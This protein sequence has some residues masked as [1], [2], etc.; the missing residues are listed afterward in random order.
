MPLMSI[1]GCTEFEK[2]IV[3]LL[4]ED[5]M[6]DHLLVVN[7]SKSLGLIS[8]LKKMGLVPDVLSPER[9][10]SGLKKS[11]GFN[12]LVTLQ[13]VNVYQSP[14]H[15]KRE[16]YEKIKFY[17]LVSNGILIIHSSCGSMFDNALLD[18]SN[19]RF[20]LELLSSE[21]EDNIGDK[22]GEGFSDNKDIHTEIIEQYRSSYNK[23][24]EQILS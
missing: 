16:I 9:I 17:G 20:L 23:L 22:T 24:K 11:K 15:M 12:V 13:D 7:G 18:F 6:I 10:P 8:S 1:I 19:S 21:N 2:E 4:A 14:K 3:E 5:K